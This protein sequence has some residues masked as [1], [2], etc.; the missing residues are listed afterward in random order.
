[1]KKNVI[2]VVFLVIALFFVSPTL[3]L[4]DIGEGITCRTT[5]NQPL[6][7]DE[8]GK[9]PR[10]A[11]GLVCKN[12]AT[13]PNDISVYHCE[14]GEGTIEGVIGQVNPP[15]AVAR[16]GFGATGLSNFFNTATQLI[17]IVGGIIFVFMVIISALQW[18][19][20][21]GDKEAVAGARD[22]LTFAIIGIVILALAF[23]IIRVLGQITGF[24]FFAGQNP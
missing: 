16:L 14:K 21:G 19:L 13:N 24:E 11:V 18:I 2:C 4:A 1:M 10:C 9:T 23:V 15:D 5:D 8:N 20:S 22:R 12:I 6:P 3:A 7:P 17:Y